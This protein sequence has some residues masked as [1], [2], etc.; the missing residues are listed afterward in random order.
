MRAPRTSIRDLD[1]G[2]NR[3]QRCFASGLATV[4]FVAATGCGNEQADTDDDLAA[5][6]DTVGGVV[7]VYNAGVAPEWDLAPVASIGP[8]SAME[9]TP[10]AFGGVSNVAFGPQGNLYVADAINREVRV[11]GLDGAHVRTFGRR[12]QGP[13]EFEDL[14]SVAWAGRTFLTLDFSNGRIGEFS[15]EGGWLGQRAEFPGLSGSYG[16]FRFYPVSR[17]QA[18]VLT[19]SARGPLL[20]AGHDEAGPTG[21]TLAHVA[22]PEDIINSVRCYGADVIRYFNVPFSPSV[23]QHPGMDGAIYSAMTN[24]YRIAVTKGDDTVRVIE[25]QLVADPLDAAAWESGTTD[26]RDFLSENPG[27]DCRPGWPGKPDARPFIRNLFVAPDGRLWVQVLRT[28]GN[29]WEVFGPDGVLLG[30]LPSGDRSGARP[31]AFGP[32]RLLAIVRQDSLGLDH[33][34][35]YRVV[36]PR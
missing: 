7:H 33:V 30:T 32:D 14:Y 8:Q 15:A 13:G 35:L 26:Y 34:E 25:R 5:R 19:A 18:Y 2:G 27:A 31:P 11:F 28:G 22:T 21:D 36:E 9:D 3:Q 1:P 20:F 4:L 12:G 17:D 29:R 16:T 24:R 10:V 6:V 23:V